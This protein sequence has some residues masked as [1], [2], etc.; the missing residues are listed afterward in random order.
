MQTPV[1]EIKSRLDIVDVIKEYT[2]LK[3]VGAN[4]KALCPFHNEKTPSFIVS[5]EKQV[6]HCFGCGEGGDLFTFIEKVESVDFVEALRIL[7]QKA[8]VELKQFDRKQLSQRNRLLDIHEAAASFW[9]QKLFSDEGK[10]ARDYLKD[11]GFSKEAVLKWKLGYALD[12]WDSVLKYL[13][14]KNYTEKELLLSGLVLSGEGSNRVYDRFRSRIMFPIFDH[15]SQIVGFTGRVLASDA[16]A[17]KY[18]NSPQTAIYDK[19]GVVYG[20]NFAKTHIKERDQ[21]VLVEGNTDVISS[22]EAGVENVVAVSGT[23]LTARQLELMKRYSENIIV[24]FDKDS[25]GIKALERSI[26]LALNKGFSVRVALLPDD[27]DPDSLIRKSVDDW[28]G[29]I[30]NAVNY[31]DYYFKKVE[32]DFDLKE[33]QGKKKAARVMLSILAQIPDKVEREIYLQQLSGLLQVSAEVLQ[34]SLPENK[35]RQ[36]AS[37]S[38]EKTNSVKVD[39]NRQ[40]QKR[41]EILLACLLAKPELIKKINPDLVDKIWPDSMLKDLYSELVLFYNQINIIDNKKMS[42][43]WQTEFIEKL[44]QDE[45]PQLVKFAETIKMLSD[46]LVSSDVQM[47]REL[48]QQLNFLQKK[49][50]Q[51]EIAKL[52]KNIALSGSDSDLEKLNT[53]IRKLSQL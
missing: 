9:Q 42:A 22:H 29:L 52:Q 46:D 23:A 20:L 10:A 47:D 36:S 53:L 15:N 49:Y 37:V 30:A 26:F 48:Q 1:D 44:S 19:S 31:V 43:A 17:A 18:V 28:R 3:Q 24:A 40:T 39:E 7:A 33:T 4:W 21:I 32:L 25:A 8:N 34:Q 38:Q 35:S 6:W 11:R 45:K 50:L 14:G 27:Y 5:Q 51:V 41:S 12:S 16:K 13:S 2:N